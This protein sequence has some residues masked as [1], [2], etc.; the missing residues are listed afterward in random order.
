MQSK[1]G[2]LNSSEIKSALRKSELRFS[3]RDALLKAGKNKIIFVFSFFRLK[4][5]LHINN[6][7]FT[8]EL[9]C[10]YNNNL[11]RQQALKQT[12]LTL[13]IIAEFV[14]N[15]VDRRGMRKKVCERLISILY[16]I[17][18]DGNSSLCIRNIVKICSF[19]VHN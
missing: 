10:S 13:E 7:C 8:E 15:E 11:N 12:E 19:I 17:K 14:F 2:E 16:C 6:L 5:L 9:I 1:S 3:A 4:I 18:Y